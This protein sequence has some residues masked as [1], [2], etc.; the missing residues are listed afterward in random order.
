MF[1]EMRFGSML[2]KLKYEDPAALTAKQV[3]Q[4]ATEN[5][6]E[7]AGLDAGVLEEGKLADI[8]IMDTGDVH[9]APVHDVIQQIVYCGKSSDVRNVII[10]GKPVHD[11][12]RHPECLSEEELVG[13]AIALAED[14]QRTIPYGR[15]YTN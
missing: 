2:Q 1:E 7:I 9:F 13:E 5:A 8:V 12:W 3:Y 10:D 4:M 14:R 6:A 11:G 15:L